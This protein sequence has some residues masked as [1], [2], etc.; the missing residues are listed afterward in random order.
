MNA[1]W[2]FCTGFWLATIISFIATGFK[3]GWMQGLMWVASG[4][5]VLALFF[6]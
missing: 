2:A 4:G 5:S 3:H 1:L 6:K